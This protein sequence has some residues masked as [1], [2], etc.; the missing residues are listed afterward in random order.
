MSADGNEDL[1]T[2]ISRAEQVLAQRWES[3]VRLEQDER[4]S[5]ERRRNLLLRC[6]VLSGPDEAPASVI[7]KRARQSG[8]DP[9]DPKSRPAVGLFRDWAGLEFLGSVAELG[10]CPRF[11]GG[12]RESGFFIMEDLGGTRDLDQVLTCGSAAQAERALLLL[13]AALGQMHAASAGGVDQYQRIRDALGPGDGFQRRSLGAHARDYA[14]VMAK[15]CAA[16]GVAVPP[17]FFDDIE[18]IATAMEEPG[19]L[20]AYTHGDA[21]PD[22][23]MLAGERLCLID[24]EFG[25]F[26][27]ALLDGVYGR[28]RFP[29]CWCVRDI[30]EPIVAEMEAVYRRE[31]VKGCPA[32]KDDAIYFR[33]VADA[34]GYWILENLAHLFD[35][36]LQ[37]EEPKGT[38]TNRQRIL[39]RLAAFTQVAERSGHLAAMRGTCQRLLDELRGR[40]RDNMPPYDAFGQSVQLRDD[41]VRQITQAVSTNQI[42]RVRELLANNPGL[43]KAKALDA[44]QT[45]L[46]YL[47]VDTQDLDLVQLLLEQGADWR[48]TTRSG[49]TVLA[50]ACSHS[51]PAVVDVLLQCGADLNERDAWGS[52]PIYG[53]MSNPRMLRH[54]IECGARLDLK[55]VIDLNRLDVAEQI[56]EQDPAPAR[57]RFGTGITLL[58]DAAR[59]GNVQAIELL[60]RYTSDIDPQTNWQATP[61]HLAAFNGHT[62]TA[63]LLLQRGANVN[64]EDDRGRTPLALAEGKRHASCAELLGNH[65]G[66]RLIP[67]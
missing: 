2:L 50:R 53:A 24:Y 46:L 27:H 47:A 63:E 31:L 3:A 61:L 33:A 15:R 23:C 55:A 7:I 62:S 38:A 40:W 48:T 19:E 5:E 58:H 32:A 21:C 12:D 30:P 41:E 16:L 59:V 64:A 65:G 36:A 35:R 49:W 17:A 45:P 66:T 37:Y 39:T 42:E 26:R 56:L 44:D 8:Y 67:K 18:T 20:L 22:N 57:I 9:D 60:L 28:I 10:A 43:A 14:P 1:G 29:T 6:K 34:C 51:T 13:A 54:L 52:L 25:N 11:Y 4:L